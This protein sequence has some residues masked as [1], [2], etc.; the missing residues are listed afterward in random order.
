MGGFY[1]YIKDRLDSGSESINLLDVDIKSLL[2]PERKDKELMTEYTIMIGDDQVIQD[3]ADDKIYEN[4]LNIDF[5]IRKGHKNKISMAHVK[6]RVV[7][8]EGC[9]I[10]VSNN[11]HIFYSIQ[12]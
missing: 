8:I 1:Q 12:Y 6:R 9:P 5:G 2:D 3:D 7:D 4:D 10:G 11:N